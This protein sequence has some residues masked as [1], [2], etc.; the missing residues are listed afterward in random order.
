MCAGRE[1]DDNLDAGEMMRPRCLWTYVSDWAYLDSGDR[2]SRPACDADNGVT[3]PDELGAQ[4]LADKAGRTGDE[5]A[6]QGRSPP[7]RPRPIAR[8]VCRQMH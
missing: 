4:P 8:A 3:A 6:C 5:N 1:V 7:L 2:L